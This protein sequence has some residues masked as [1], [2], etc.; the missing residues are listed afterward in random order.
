MGTNAVTK[1]SDKNR[2]IIVSESLSAYFLMLRNYA[3][4]E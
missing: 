3:K 4:N 1:I 2:T